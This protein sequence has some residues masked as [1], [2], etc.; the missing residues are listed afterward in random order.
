MNEMRGT[1]K[2]LINDPANVV[3]EMLE[4]FVAAHPKIVSLASPRVVARS[5][6]AGDKVGMT[7]GGGSGHEPAMVG[8]VGLG[9]ADTAAAGNIFAAPSSDIVLESIRLAN[10]GRGVVLVYGNYS[11][12][13]LNCRL[14]IQRAKAE[15]IDVRSVFISDDIA[16]AKKEESDKRRGVAGD[17]PIFKVTGAAAEAGMPLEDVERVAR[18]ANAA[19][20]SMGVALSGAELPGA[21]RPTFVCG[22]DEMEVGLGVHGEPGV[23]RQALLSADEVGRLLAGRILEDL[24]P[25]SDSQLAVLING[26]GATPLLEQY[27]VYRSVRNFL[28]ARKMN[29]ARS[30]VGEYITSLQMAGLHVTIMLLDDELLSLLD[31]PART[32]AFV[33]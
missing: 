13:I 33:Q 29:V 8:Y 9:F 16:S 31:A 2:K 10:H 19:T 11:G 1:M 22:H 25:P 20:R 5:H 28:I 23:G 30:Y 17:I 14:A 6:P 24:E 12:D 7:I 32:V 26:L 3:D 15:G 27:L 21:S 18:K 4:A